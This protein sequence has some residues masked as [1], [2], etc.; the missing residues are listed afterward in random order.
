MA[1]VKIYYFGFLSELSGKSYD[2]VE[3]PERAG[4]KVKELVNERIKPF[5]DTI[6]ILV[7]DVS[8]TPDK[9]VKPGDTVKLL[10][11]IGGG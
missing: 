8:V 5:L 6:I 4:V 11:H 1:K 9:R 2:E 3:L 10:P 7:N